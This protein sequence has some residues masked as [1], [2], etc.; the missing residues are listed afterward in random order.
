M[1]GHAEYGIQIPWD[2]IQ[3]YKEGN[4][5]TCLI[6]DGVLSELHPSQKKCGSAYVSYLKH[7]KVFGYIVQ[8]AFMKSTDTFYLLKHKTKTHL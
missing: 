4:F 7:S 1:S 2:V 6:Q 8:T 3:S 5:D